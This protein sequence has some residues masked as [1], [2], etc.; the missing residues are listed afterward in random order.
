M[1]QEEQKKIEEKMAKTE[2]TDIDQLKPEQIEELP[3]EQVRALKLAKVKKESDNF[4]GFDINQLKGYPSMMQ[5]GAVPN[6]LLDFD[7]QTSFENLKLV[8][9]RIKKVFDDGLIESI[10]VTQ[11]YFNMKCS[12][13][14]ANV[15]QIK[16]FYDDETQT[17]NFIG[18]PLPDNQLKAL[19][20]AIPLIKGIKSLEF[21]NN[22]IGDY[23]AA[24]LFISCFMSPTF[25]NIVFRNNVIKNSASLTLY[26]LNRTNPD[27]LHQ[28]VINGSIS[29]NE[30]LVH[31]TNELVDTH[32]LNTLDLDGLQISIN[33]AKN[34]GHYLIYS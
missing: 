19:C 7:L 26:E 32:K 27:T 18:V 29:Q 10:H 13:F 17:L 30:D 34:I 20:L 31:L 16:D 6:N 22:G 11:A 9:E 33:A 28:L 14:G 23:M 8:R 4:H 2:F 12:E 1:R 24:C 5:E 3:Q 25:E 21:N 15:L